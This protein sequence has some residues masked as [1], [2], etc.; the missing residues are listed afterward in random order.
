[1]CA[2]LARAARRRPPAAAS[3]ALDARCRVRSAPRASGTGADGRRA[4]EGSRRRGT[5]R[6][7][8][9]APA[10]WDGRSRDALS[11][12]QVADLVLDLGAEAAED[13]QLDAPILS[14]QMPLRLG[15]AADRPADVACDLPVVE[16][17]GP[18]VAAR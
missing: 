11:R 13:R 3:P 10:A 12:E 6:S 7:P 8:R 17:F 16:L 18:H 4:W 14:R 2:P 15:E 9:R 5:P 1:G